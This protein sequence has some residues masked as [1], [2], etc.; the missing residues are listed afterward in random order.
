MKLARTNQDEE[1]TR[2]LLDK[3]AKACETCQVFIAPP[4][5]FRISLPAS[6][7][8]PNRDVALE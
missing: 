5:R 4:E 3:I 2:K 6:D 7:I 1:D 8:V